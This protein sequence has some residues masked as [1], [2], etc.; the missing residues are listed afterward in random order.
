MLHIIWWVLSNYYKEG[1]SHHFQN[2]SQNLNL[3]DKINAT[4]WLR[5]KS[6]S[7]ARCKEGD[8]PLLNFSN[9]KWMPSPSDK[10]LLLVFFHLDYICTSISNW[11]T[12]HLHI[13]HCCKR[14][15]KIFW[16]LFKSIWRGRL[17]KLWQIEN[18]MHQVFFKSALKYI[19]NSLFSYI[20]WGISIIKAVVEHNATWN[21]CRDF[22][23]NLTVIIIIILQP[24]FPA[25]GWN[26]FPTNHDDAETSVIY[27]A[28]NTDEWHQVI[29]RSI[30]HIQG[31]MLWS[32]PCA[33]LILIWSNSCFGMIKQ[34]KY[35]TDRVSKILFPPWPDLIPLA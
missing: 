21:H 32:R 25:V 29:I 13:T 18:I 5:T 7:L 8:L 9:L 17:T 10:S 19:K 2:F 20:L 1:V 26:Y 6:P 23:L 31:A 4:E 16:I 11:F 30:C 33:L 34:L 3:I 22:R 14:I 12:R 35:T 28:P 27:L 24:I 15:N